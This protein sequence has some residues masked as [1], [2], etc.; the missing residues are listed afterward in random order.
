MGAGVVCA[1]AA[2][3]GQGLPP[4]EAG[5]YSVT[6]IDPLPGDSSVTLFAINNRG[7]A[8]G[9]S[10]GSPISNQR[11][12]VYRP[13]VNGAAGTVTVIP[14][15][16]GKTFSVPMDI[17]DNGVVVGYAQS[18]WS[19]EQGMTPWVW[20]S[21]TGAMSGLPGRG[22]ATLNNIN[23]G[24]AFVGRSYIGVTSLTCY[25]QGQVGSAATATFGSAN[26]YSSSQ[27]RFVDINDPGQVLYTV[28]GGLGAAVRREPGGAV[29]ALPQSSEGYPRTYT[30]AINN[31]GLCLARYERNVG[32]QYFSKAFVW[33]PETGA[34]FVGTPGNF[35]FGRGLNNPGQVVGESGTNRN[36][37]ISIWLSMPDG[38][39]VD[40]RGLPATET[41]LSGV[42][43]INDAGQIIARAFTPTANFAVVLTPPAV[44]LPACV[45]DL[46]GQGGVIGA[47]GQL[48]NNDFIAFISLFFDA[49]ARADV[50][51]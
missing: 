26:D 27:W 11:P 44:Q 34:R 49:D 2:A 50:G 6:R 42:W 24:G 22:V 25:Y 45:A 1:G 30:W 40:V 33:S 32:S 23:N 41:N 19:D 46:G 15:P 21:A 36:S 28:N 3:L 39:T 31:S 18:T 29:T 43:G 10:Y 16:A 7:E 4:V 51:A 5:T 48:D 35:V 14:F 47:D 13:G 17:N 37:V 9:V 12:F 20:D 8:V 38:R